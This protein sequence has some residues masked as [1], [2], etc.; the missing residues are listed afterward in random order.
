MAALNKTKL[1][2]GNLGEPPAALVSALDAFLVGAG[3][4]TI[5]DLDYTTA[6]S[7]RDTSGVLS[8]IYRTEGMF[9][10]RASFYEDSTSLGSAEDQINAWLATGDNLRVHHIRDLTPSRVRQVAPVSVLVVWADTLLP[11][12]DPYRTFPVI[13]E[14]LEAIDVG[15]TGQARMLTVNGLDLTS[16]VLT[17]KNAGNIDWE[18]GG[19]AMAFLEPSSG[20]VFQAIPTGANYAIANA[21]FSRPE[22]SYLIAAISSDF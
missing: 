14:A 4:I 10:Y 12:N 13:L 11:P 2:R 17:A 7:S 6:E 20:A 9:G 18:V 22:Y 3:N 16:P 21:N 15:Q 19:C 8:L 1:F 5:V